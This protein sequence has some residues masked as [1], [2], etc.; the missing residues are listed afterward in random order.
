MSI[1]LLDMVQ[2]Q[3]GGAAMSQIGKFLGTDE[4]KASAGMSAALPAILGS[5]VQK[6]ASESGAKGILDLLS[7]GGH[8]G[9]MFDNLG[10]L[11]GGGNATNSMMNNGGSILQ[12]LMGNKTQAITDFIIRSTGLDKGAT[13][14][15]L[16]M[17]APMIMGMIGKQ[18]SKSGMGASGLM[19]MLSGQKSFLKDAMPAGMG[20]LLGFSGFPDAKEAIDRTANTAKAAASEGSSM[21]SRILPLALILGLCFA[22]YKY[23]TSGENLIADATNAT[24]EKTKDAANAVGDAAGDAASVVAATAEGAVDAVGDAANA[25]GDAIGDAANATGDMLS[26]AAN[27]VSEAAKKALDNVKFA[28][29]S[30]GE[31]LSNVLGS[32][33]AKVGETI[34]F[35]NLTFKT[36]SAEIDPTT[37]TEVMNLAQVLK[38]Y[39]NIKVEIGGHTDNTG[40]SANNLTLS[41]NRASSVAKYLVREG[42]ID[43]NRITTF[44]YGDGKPVADNGTEEG[45]AQNRRIELKIVK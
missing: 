43:R 6:G 21:L 22:G 5:V 15:I 29:G 31:K 2:S 37:A 18:V 26:D 39:P 44:G 13:G 10:A 28:A 24:I 42:G 19:D 30:A 12:F 9:S 33:K 36:G 41:N 7:S 3:L 14:S 38:A 1:N 4:T 11:L 40:D 35:Q 20:S 27:T 17:A 34:V 45:R 25:T 8:N 23:F 16:R 32:G